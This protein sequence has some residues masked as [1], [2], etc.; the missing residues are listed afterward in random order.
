ML[1][2]SKKKESRG[3]KKWALKK[4]VGLKNGPKKLWWE[5]HRYKLLISNLEEIGF[6]LLFGLGVK[7]NRFAT[8]FTPKNFQSSGFPIRLLTRKNTFE[9]LLDTLRTVLRQILSDF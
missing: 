7:W 1:T 4:N 9:I 6:E 8:F 3:K 2:I 5:A